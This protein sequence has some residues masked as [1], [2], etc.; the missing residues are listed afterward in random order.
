M[1]LL[2]LGAAL[3]KFFAGRYIK[4]R[5]SRTFCIV[6]AA[7]GCLEFPYGMVLGVF[8]FIVLGRQSVAKQFIAKS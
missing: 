4:Q 8:T 1:F 2:M 5:K 6:V 3:T 7:L